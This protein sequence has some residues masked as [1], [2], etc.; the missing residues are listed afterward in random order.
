MRKPPPKKK[1]G[2]GTGP[3]TINGAVLDVRTLSA[4]CGWSQ[5]TTRG[6][7]DRRLIPLRRVG[8]RI[9]FIRS[10][11]EHWL[12]GL[13]GVT[14][15]EARDNAEARCNKER[16]RHTWRDDDPT[17]KRGTSDAKCSETFHSRQDTL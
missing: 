16:G 17:N 9:I 7:V 5:K 2:Q 8:G 12:A 15:E 1:K 14:L 10:E 13:E 4:F 3:H 6:L 11:I